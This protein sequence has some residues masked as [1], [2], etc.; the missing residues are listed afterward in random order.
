MFDICAI[1]ANQNDKG[2][3]IKPGQTCDEANDFKLKPVYEA[4]PDM[5]EAL[6]ELVPPEGA[7]GWW[8]PTCKREVP[9][10]EVTYEQYHEHC[11]TYLA[12]IN[13]D[14]WL[15]EARQALAKAEGKGV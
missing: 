10:I 14:E 5:Y 13:T 9:G 4:T 6:K 11:G 12:D 15:D 8:C 1:C 7:S 3:C 2:K